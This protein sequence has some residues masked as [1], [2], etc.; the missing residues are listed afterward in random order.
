MTTQKNTNRDRTIN[1]NR[2]AIGGIRKHFA[3]VPTIL[4]GGKPTAPNDA[5]ATL[6]AAIDAIDAA[7][8][9]EQTF[10]GAV[11]AQHTAIATSNATLT[12]LK[13]LVQSQLGSSDG[14][15]G[16]FGFSSPKRQAPTEATKAA[17]VAK[18]A[19]T[20][21]ARQTMGSRQK[22]KIKG[23]VPLADV[24]A[25]HSGTPSSGSPPASPAAPA[26]GVSTNPS[27]T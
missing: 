4:L 9:A 7:V 17:A 12:E 26:G 11:A 23:A 3:S 14:V 1:N 22:A 5:I 8:S 6:Q 25:A 24:T 13:T 27:R 19:A 18:R 2:Q 10:H 15:L 21:T 16:D 20:R